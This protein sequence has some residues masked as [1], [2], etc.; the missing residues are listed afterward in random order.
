MMK[1]KLAVTIDIDPKTY[2]E[3]YGI[4][5]KDLRQDVKSSFENAVYVHFENVRGLHHDI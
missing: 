2:C 1:I 5:L 3:E 4:D